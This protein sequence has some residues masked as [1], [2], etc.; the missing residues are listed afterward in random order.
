MFAAQERRLV[1]TAAFGISLALHLLLILIFPRV[2]LIFEG[3]SGEGIMAGGIPVQL[4]SLTPV[5]SSATTPVAKAG[6]GRT[7]SAQPAEPPAPRELPTE[8]NPQQVPGVALS[9]VKVTQPPAPAEPPREQQAPP[10]TPPDITRGEKSGI[11][12]SPATTAGELLTSEKGQDIVQA[13]ARPLP[14]AGSTESKEEKLEPKP[15]SL[16]APL[17][18]QPASPGPRQSTTAQETEGPIREGGEEKRAGSGAGGLEGSGSEPAP[19]PAPAVGN[20]PWL[21]GDAPDYPKV[22]ADRGDKG[23]VRGQVLIWTD[24]RIEVRQVASSGNPVMDKVARG[25]IAD[26]W[27][28]AYRPPAGWVTVVEWAVHFANP[29]KGVVEQLGAFNIRE[30]KVPSTGPVPRPDQQQLTTP[31]GGVQL[32]QTQS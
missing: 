24:G 4:V 17:S 2:P 10:A 16:P 22:A 28:A 13:P 11:P 15:Q 7:P 1:R 19:P 25:T 21:A 14:R 8:P 31:P 29:P 20:G 12:A 3:T 27:K 32:N 30:D 18:Q 23:V 26:R 9:P 5:S 6:R